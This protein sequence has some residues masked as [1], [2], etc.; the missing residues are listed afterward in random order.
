MIIKKSVRRKNEGNHKHEG[1]KRISLAVDRKVL[2][3]LDTLVAE[4]GRN[5]S[6]VIRSAILTYYF[7]HNFLSGGEYI[8]ADIDLW[9]V[10]LDELNEKGSASFW[11]SV[12]NMGFKYGLKCKTK[13]FANMQDV[14]EYMES[15]NWFKVK[16]E[17]NGATLVHHIRKE[18]KILKEFLGSLFK[19]MEIPVEIIE[20]LN[21]IVVVEK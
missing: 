21:K 5:K 14:L 10:M 6:E 3:A 19:A 4:K 11:E 2:D 18:R 20:G 17:E 8:I 1:T 12:R 13:G 7:H 9:S 15:W 16:A